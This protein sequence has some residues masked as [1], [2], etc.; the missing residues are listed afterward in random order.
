MP[1]FVGIRQGRSDL[2]FF[3][4]HS[5][6]T[7]YIHPGVYVEEIQVGLKSIVGAANSVTAFVGKVTKG[8]DLA[9]VRP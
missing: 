6:I 8:P 2:F 9:L 3:E 1:D 7:H 4:Q 5:Y